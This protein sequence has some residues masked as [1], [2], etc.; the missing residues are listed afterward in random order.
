MV[1]R[2]IAKKLYSTSLKVLRLEPHNQVSYPG[3]FAGVLDLCRDS[4]QSDLVDSKPRQSQL[5]FRGNKITIKYFL[6]FKIFQ[7]FKVILNFLKIT[8]KK[9]ELTFAEKFGKSVIISKFIVYH[10]F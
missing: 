1:L 3:H 9:E 8:S 4:A 10:Q 7:H 6:I 5:I 2:G